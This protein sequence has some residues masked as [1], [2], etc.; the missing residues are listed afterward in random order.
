MSDDFQQ[1]IRGDQFDPSEYGGCLLLIYPVEYHAA[2][3]TKFSKPGEPDPA[4]VD[5]HIVVLDRVDPQTHAPVV[6]YGARIFGR[7]MVPQL[8]GGVGGNAILGRLG[9]GQNTKGNPPWILMDFSEQDAALARQYTAQFPDPRKTPVAPPTSP[10]SAPSGTGGWGNA[11]PNI[12]GVPVPQAAQWQ[13][14]VESQGPPPQWATQYPQ[15]PAQ[16]APA[17]PPQQWGTPTAPTAPA[18]ATA[19]VASSGHDP[20]LAAFLASKGVNVALLPPD[21]DLKMI[22]ST[23]GA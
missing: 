14:P 13:A 15:V 10:V 12:Q 5:C 2:I 16:A 18:P 6:K 3:P 8:K 7:A 17:A 9:Q 23:F 22:A 11:A 20:Q 4:A 19:A 21:A 1:P